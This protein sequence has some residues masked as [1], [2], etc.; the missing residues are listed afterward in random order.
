[1]V[2]LGSGTSTVW[3]AYAL[4]QTGGRIVSLDHDPHYAQNTREMLRA[5]GLDQV[6]EVRDAPLA[7]ITVR[8]ADFRWYDTGAL[9]DLNDIDL[10]LVDGPPGS[11]GPLS[12]YPALSV[13]RPRLAA[14]ATVVLDDLSREDE[15]ETLRRWVYEDCTLTVEATLIGQHAVLSCARP[16]APAQRVP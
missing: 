13:L 5:H 3:L 16:T 9:S 6:A 2:E 12:R 4:E 15:Q 7:P 11:I 10:L 14:G 8:E 1:V